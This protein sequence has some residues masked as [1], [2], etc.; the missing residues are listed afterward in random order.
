[1]EVGQ[2]LLSSGELRDAF[3]KIMQLLIDKMDMQRGCL[4]ILDESSG[5][6][7]IE[8]AVGLT[9]DE[10]ERGIY[11]VGEGI[12]GNVVAT[13]KARII[14]DVRKEPDFLNRT[15]CRDMEKLDHPVELPVHSH[16]DRRPGRRRH[17]LRQA[18]RQP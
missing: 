16:Q 14:P 7:R 18:V 11:D 6:L 13:G 2:I 9:H 5:R 4:V 3:A 12:T 17:V 10:I 15:F 1:M 8:A